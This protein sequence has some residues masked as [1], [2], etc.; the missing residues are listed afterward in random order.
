MHNYKALKVAGNATVRKQ[1]VVDDPAVEAVAE[2]KDDGGVITTHSVHARAERSHEELQVVCKSYNSQTGETQDDSVK[3]YSLKEV[4]REIDHC[5]SQVTKL[6]AEQAE[7][8]QL[9]T[10]LKAL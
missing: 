1:K 5:K 2:V 8:E 10:D 6:E 4:K 3:A 9:E 7:W